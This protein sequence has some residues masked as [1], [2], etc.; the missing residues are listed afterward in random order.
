MKKLLLVAGLLCF[1]ILMANV[2]ASQAVTVLV[3][4]VDG[5]GY[6]GAVGLKGAYG[7]AADRNNNG[8][9]ESNDV[10][11]DLNE[12]G[13]VATG[14]GDDFDNRSAG[15]AADTNG[16][17]WTDVSLSTSFDDRPGV[18]DD[19]SFTFYFS[20]PELG[21]ADYGLD[22]FVNFVYADYDANP[23][24][25]VVEGISVTLLGNSDGG[26]LDG[27]I[28]RAY[29]LVSWL[30]MLDGEVTIEI[31]APNEP[32]VAFD[33]ALLDVNPIETP[34]VPIPGAVFLLGSGL[35]GLVGLRKR[36]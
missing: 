11:P 21:D 35:L 16:G 9:L 4:D 34:Q 22:H 2:P 26:G 5:F 27:Y 28:W 7:G 18:A 10:L 3:G 12:N 15:E 36:S 31:N 6:G 14:Q 33:Y 23:M 32:Y 25:A 13:V 17:M 29:A 8:L 24:T 30:D 19:A 1:T 20:V